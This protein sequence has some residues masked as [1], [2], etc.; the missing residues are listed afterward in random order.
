MESSWWIPGRRQLVDKLTETLWMRFDNKPIRYII[1]TSVN[2]EHT[3]G[4]RNA[5]KH[6]RIPAMRLQA[7]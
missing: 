7:R 3:G 5:G 1:N 4:K 2:N 6:N